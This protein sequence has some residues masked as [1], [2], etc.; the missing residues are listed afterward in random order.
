MEPSNL[1]YRIKFKNEVP[2][3]ELVF[4]LKDL[5][6][7]GFER[8]TGT[9]YLTI[10][11]SEIYKKVYALRAN[12]YTNNQIIDEVLLLKPELNKGEK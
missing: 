8:A 5:N 1:E 11:M 9:L 4:L 12:G 3:E 10:D 6:N 7:K 2:L